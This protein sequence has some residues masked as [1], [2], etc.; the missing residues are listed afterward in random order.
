MNLE[1]KLLAQMADVVIVVDGAGHYTDVSPSVAGYGFDPTSMIGRS[2]IDLTHPDDRLQL[3]QVMRDLLAGRLD[4][5]TDREYRVM[6]PDGRQI[7]VEGLPR[8]CGSTT[9]ATRSATSRYLET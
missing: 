9:E 7:W 2:N 5:N 4:Q 8:P 3:R 1:Q 6:L